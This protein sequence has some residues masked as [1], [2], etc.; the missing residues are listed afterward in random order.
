[1]IFYST[2]ISG[3]VYYIYA[4]QIIKMNPKRGLKYLN[5][6]EALIKW[7]ILLFLVEVDRLSLITIPFPLPIQ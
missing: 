2:N 1:M 4:I 5:R 3:E 6:V 7:N